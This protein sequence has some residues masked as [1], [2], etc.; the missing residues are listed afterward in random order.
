M[1]SKNKEVEIKNFLKSQII[2]KNINTIEW[3][4]IKKDIKKKNQSN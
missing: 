2:E 3:K 1:E 4:N